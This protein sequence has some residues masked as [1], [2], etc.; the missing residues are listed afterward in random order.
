MNEWFI[1]L[2]CE[3][4]NSEICLFCTNKMYFIDIFVKVGILKLVFCFEVQSEYLK[5]FF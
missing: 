2:F 1:L 4:K 5:T 3:N